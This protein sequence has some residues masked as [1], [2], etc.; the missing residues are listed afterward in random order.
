MPPDGRLEFSGMVLAYS[1]LGELGSTT[2][3]LMIGSRRADADPLPGVGDARGHGQKR[4]WSGDRDELHCR[5]RAQ[6]NGCVQTWSLESPR[7][8]PNRGEFFERSQRP[9]AL[10]APFPPQFRT[11][12][13]VAHVAAAG[14]PRTARSRSSI[15]GS[16]VAVTD[17]R[18]SCW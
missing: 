9:A 7:T 15:R 5:D 10:G 16:T 17:A 14:Q 18:S 8:D 6:T 3:E 11:F 2:M 1:V 4:Q 13:R 12:E